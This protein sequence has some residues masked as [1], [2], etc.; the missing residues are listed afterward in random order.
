M[1]RRLV[2][3]IAAVSLLLFSPLMYAQQAKPTQKPTRP[4]DFKPSGK[5]ILMVCGDENKTVVTCTSIGD[6]TVKNRIELEM[7]HKV[8]RI[9]HDAPADEMLKAANAADLVIITESTLSGTIGSKIVSTPTAVLS[10]EAFLQD[11][12]LQVNPKGKNIEGRTAE[13][14]KVSDFGTLHDTQHSINIVNPKHPLAAGLSGT[15]EDLSPARD[16]AL[17]GGKGSCAQRRSRRHPP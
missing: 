12:F 16:D 6:V 4:P 9:G 10:S 14:M 7:G 5:N 1:T 11:E 15:R 3:T 13:D 8:T 2:K 17:G